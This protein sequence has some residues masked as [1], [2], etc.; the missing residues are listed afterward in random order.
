MKTFK[1][2]SLALAVML[3]GCSGGSSSGGGA[4]SGDD[5]NSGQTV[6]G[7]ATAPGGQIAQFEQQSFMQVAMNFVITPAAAA[8][9]GLEPVEGALVELIRV[10]DTG[11]Q[12]GD[13][14]ATSQT[15]ITG[16]YELTLPQGVDLS[17]D[18]IV[19]ITGQNDMELRAQVVEQDVD[20]SPMSEF[21]L[22]KF[23]ESGADL[24]ELV[25]TDVVKLSGK[26]EEFD[27]TAGANLDEMFATLEQEVG[28]F[29]ENQVAAVSAPEGDGSTIAGDYFS[30]AF[31]IE[32]GDEDGSGYGE[33]AHDLWLSDFS[34]TDEGN[35]TVT[36]SFAQEDSAYGD[37]YGS[38]LQ[39]PYVYYAADTETFE[40]DNFQVSFNA[41]GILTAEG[42]FEE[43]VDD[44]GFQ[45]KRYPAVTY[46]FQQ[47]KNTGLLFGLS[48]EAA[49]AYET[50]YNE[51][52]DTYSL[53]PDSKKG[54]D[55]MRALEVFSRKPSN[56]TAADLSGDYG[57]VWFE[58]SLFGSGIEMVTEI[59]TVTFDGFTVDV[60]EAES[61][62]LLVS[63]SGV[64]YNPGT[65]P[66]EAGVILDVQSDGSILGGEG[67]IVGFVNES[68]T[69]IDFTESEGAEQSEAIFGKTMMVKLPD[70][71]L[72][73]TGK[74][75]RLMF[76]A[77]HYDDV[78][79]GDI[80][81]T[82]SQFNSLMTM[83]STT[84][85]TLNGRFSEVVKAGLGGDAVSSVDQVSDMAFNYTVAA[86]GAAE[87]TIS[88]SEGDTVLDGFFNEDAS[89]GVFSTR[90]MESDTGDADELGM[91]V[92]ID[93]T[94]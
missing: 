94:K 60:T 77:M 83:D 56:L 62:S 91:A 78:T 37:I 85:G 76:L 35:G 39:T 53:D 50:V 18:L 47:V 90:F 71:Q 40:D 34:I 59:N 1:Y 12:L 49:V 38:D 70:S 46:T 28:A 72:T 64:T 3:A 68:G 52:N 79:N 69:Y 51:S 58:G 32:L 6:S 27:L 24:D 7:T 57:R 73:L 9:T 89:L 41:A 54:D 25:V 17:G 29:V 13:V 8:I 86:N 88:N 63:S 10:D 48:H 74:T 16:D 75:Y 5:G 87:I 80:A 31:S 21:V 65:E 66:A 23:I 81:M 14:L 20:I 84:A 43:E 33:V 45:A 2:A 4:P 61:H 15:S 93:V 42:E 30:G 22:R 82:A 44:N 92:L 11:K 67:G 26:A 55:I 19:R 36:L